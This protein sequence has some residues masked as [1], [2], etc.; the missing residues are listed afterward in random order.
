[1]KKLIK[2]LNEHDNPT[3]CIVVHENRQFFV[4]DS[5]DYMIKIWSAAVTGK[6]IR[7]LI[8]HTDH[9]I[10]L[11]ISYEGKVIISGCIDATIKL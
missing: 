4:S 8:G 10:S 2:I 5:C 7:E 9:I 1:M 6:V 3:Y 11:A